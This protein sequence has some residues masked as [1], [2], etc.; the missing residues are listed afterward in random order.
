MT[1]NQIP[2]PP[3]IPPA[4]AF[5][6][7]REVNKIVYVL[8]N[9]FVGSLGV[10]RFLR[11]Q[12]GLGILMLLI[13]SWITLGIWPIVDFIIGLVKLGKYDGENFRFNQDGSWALA[14]RQ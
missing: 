6:N 3:P 14:D 12:V 13:G 4:A 8:C 5:S 7:Q 2:T 10:H 1:E 9:F 11:G